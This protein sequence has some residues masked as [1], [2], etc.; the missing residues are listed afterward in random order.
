MKQSNRGAAITEN[1]ASPRKS[2]CCLS[3]LKP[4]MNMP[5]DIDHATRNGPMNNRQ[6]SGLGQ[7][8]QWTRTQADETEDGGQVSVKPMFPPNS[9]SS[10]GIWDCEDLRFDKLLNK[11]EKYLKKPNQKARVKQALD[12]SK[13]SSK[14]GTQNVSS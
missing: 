1:D 8:S 13:V 5:I 4:L 9:S 12:E 6:K 10:R 14:L 2:Q 7:A 11:Y 3:R